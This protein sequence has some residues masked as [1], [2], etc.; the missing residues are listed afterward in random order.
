M[1]P[2]RNQ[3]QAVIFS[4]LIKSL[5]LHPDFQSDFTNELYCM[6]NEML[7]AVYLASILLPTN[8]MLE[9]NNNN[10]YEIL[11]LAKKFITKWQT[12][13]LLPFIGEVVL[14]IMA[15]RLFCY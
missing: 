12:K 8:N 13:I 6:S 4:K 14:L 11:L 15:Q 10:E 7:R 5:E 9:E 1:N 3:T 2:L